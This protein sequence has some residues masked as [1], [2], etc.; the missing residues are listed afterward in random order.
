MPRIKTT[1]PAPDK[2]KGQRSQELP[3]YLTRY[4]PVWSQPKW[5]ESD[6]WR[7][8]VLNQPFAT[9]CRETLI[10]N[11]ITLDWK[12]E[13]RDSQLRDEYRDEIDYYTK[14]L[15]HTG[16]YDYTQIV[17]WLLADMLDLPFGGAS[18]LGYMGDSP[19]NRLVWMRPLDGG[20]LFPT[21]SMKYPVGQSIKEN[22][23][24]IV[25]FPKHAVARLYM[26]PR[27]ELLREGWGMAPPEKIYLAIELLRRG[28]NYY[29]NLLLDTPEVGILDLMDMAKEDA[30][31]WVKSWRDMLTGIDAFKIPVLYQHTQPAK[32][33]PFTR[34]PAEITY[35]KTT[36]RYA[37]ITAAGY[38]MSLS[39]IGLQ[40]V[41]GGGE[42]LAGS[43]RQERRM[44]K[45]GFGRLKKK[46]KYFFDRILP[47]YLEFKW[48]DLDDEMSVAIGRARLASA[49]AFGQMITDNV[50][51]PKEARL[52]LIADG[53]ITISIP[54]EIPENEL[55]E[56]GDDDKT[57]S[58][59]RPS[60]LGRPVAATAGG[61]GEV[62]GGVFTQSI[63]ATLFENEKLLDILADASI[64]TRSDIMDTDLLDAIELPVTD[65]KND[66]D[67]KYLAYSQRNGISYEDTVEDF[68]SAL[69][70]VIYDT[71]NYIKQSLS[72]LLIMYNALDGDS[73][74]NE[75]LEIVYNRSI[76]HVSDE[77]IKIL[78]QFGEN[79]NG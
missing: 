46:V 69:E 77:I 61:H 33:I 14:F 19:E 37:A 64:K 3:L 75:L 9:I 1:Q 55:P 22:P 32:F 59:E 65:I 58:A 23:T 31:D 74:I 63:A 2:H 30:E 47:D 56:M 4:V 45:T 44:R 12:I 28:D 21:H 24:N 43:I 34:S 66:W 27:T 72:S 7:A 17:E 42:T 79:K 40:V 71:E 73:D 26:S 25:Y 57:K 68:S 5:Q 20:T 70:Y 50:L 78:K 49:T 60:M 67:E 29:A 11:V 52:Q 8:V 10:S 15:E 38:G 13:P 35:D 62:R 48:I 18:E 39:D 76:A 53:Q 6:F 41:S 16:E 51:T 36:M 54:E